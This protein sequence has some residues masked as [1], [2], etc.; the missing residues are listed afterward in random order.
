MSRVKNGIILVMI[1]AIIEAVFFYVVV[2]STINYHDGYA[3]LTIG[4][5]NDASYSLGSKKWMFF[6]WSN[7]TQLSN[8]TANFQFPFFS[9]NPSTQLVGDIITVFDFT[10]SS[11]GGTGF[12]GTLLDSTKGAKYSLDG[13]EVIVHESSPYS[14]T[15]WLKPTN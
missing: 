12:E 1:L 11:T 14:V 3:E 5:F 2:T 15:L 10:N 9:V 8:T 7:E 13:L 6:Y 4:A